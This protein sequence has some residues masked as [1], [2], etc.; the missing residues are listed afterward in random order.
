[1]SSVD[2]LIFEPIIPA[3][4]KKCHEVVDYIKKNS[5]VLKPM[6]LKYAIDRLRP[7]GSLLLEQMLEL[8]HFGGQRKFHYVVVGKYTK[9]LEELTFDGGID[10]GKYEDGSVP[11]LGGCAVRRS[12]RDLNLVPNTYTL[13]Y[14]FA[15]ET[16]ARLYMSSLS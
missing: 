5:A 14:V 8:Y 3:W 15:S 1:M 7:P 4:R 6:R 10:F 16:E 11:T 2:D 13:H 9:V 12:I